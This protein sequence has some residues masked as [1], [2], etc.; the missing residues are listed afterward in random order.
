MKKIL[1]G[2]LC[3]VCVL[4]FAGFDWG[5]RKS[6]NTATTKN[7][8]SSMQTSSTNSP[9]N[10]AGPTTVNATAIATA[11]K[12][13]GSGT[14]EEQ[15]MRMDAL[16]RVAK[17]MAAKNQPPQASQNVVSAPQPDRY[18]MPTPES[19]ASEPQVSTYEVPNSENVVSEPQTSTYETPGDQ[20]DMQ[21]FQENTQVFSNE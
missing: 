2:C 21:T 5:F 11:A 8:S 12:V 17:I 6:E 19:V 13:V 10:V 16:M 4:V 3:L 1:A 14:P 9:S 7:E 15:R 20:S 18:E